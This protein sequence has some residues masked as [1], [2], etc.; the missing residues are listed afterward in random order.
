[1]QYNLK[2]KKVFITGASGGIGRALCKKFIENGCV[3][4][5][6]STNTDKLDKLKRDLGS[7]H[8]YYKLDF[9]G[10]TSTYNPN[11]SSSFILVGPSVN[12]LRP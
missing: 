10:T 6:T 9:R 4:I 2:N 5:C 12:R 3:L 7:N 1:M 8:F 11:N